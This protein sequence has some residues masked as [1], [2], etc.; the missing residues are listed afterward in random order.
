MQHRHRHRRG[1]TGAGDNL[2]RMAAAD[3]CLE[4]APVERMADA[5]VARRAAALSLVRT[6]QATLQTHRRAVRDDAAL[7]IPAL[8]RR[9]ADQTIGNRSRQKIPGATNIFRYAGD[10]YGT[11]NVVAD[12]LEPATFSGTSADSWLLLRFHVGQHA[13]ARPALAHAAGAR[14]PASGPHRITYP[15]LDTRNKS[16]LRGDSGNRRADG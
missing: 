13:R 5:P 12:A 3:V 11:A 1:V 16:Q 2:A 8:G 14:W 7:F 6:Q 9:R 10:L 4:L 15:H